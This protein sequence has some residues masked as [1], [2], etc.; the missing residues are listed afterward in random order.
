MSA[1]C[2]ELSARLPVSMCCHDV[3]CYR[4]GIVRICM[5]GRAPLPSWPR[6]LLTG[7]GNAT[8]LT[9]SSWSW[10]WRNGL[11]LHDVAVILVQANEHSHEDGC[12]HRSDA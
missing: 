12:G 11:W 9:R 10:W 6:R 8:C 2:G 3:R 5:S 7:Q 4:H 1:Q